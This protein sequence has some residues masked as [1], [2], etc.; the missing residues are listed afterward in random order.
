MIKYLEKNN[1]NELV[2]EGYHLVDFYAEWCGPCKMMGPVLESIEDK[3]DII[4]IDVDKFPDLAQ[5]YRVMSIPDLMIFKDGEKILESV[6][7]Q[8]KEDLEEVISNL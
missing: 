5:E 6:G 2:R 4:K 8:S 3:I 1:F 7:F